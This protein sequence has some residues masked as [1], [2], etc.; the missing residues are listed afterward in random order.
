MNSVKDTKKVGGLIIRAGVG[1]LYRIG[2][3]PNKNN[4]GR[5]ILCNTILLIYELENNME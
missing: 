5:F 2:G 4:S 3:I 1:G